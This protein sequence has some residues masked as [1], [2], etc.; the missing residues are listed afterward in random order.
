MAGRPTRSISRKGLELYNVDGELAHGPPHGPAAGR[1]LAVV[2]VEGDGRTAAEVVDR[3]PGG[4]SLAV[5]RR[6]AVGDRLRVRP[7]AEPDAPWEEV[8]VRH[9]RPGAGRLA[10][11]VPVRDRVAAGGGHRPGPELRSVAARPANARVRPFAAARL[12]DLYPDAVETVEM[13]TEA[14][15]QRFYAG[16]SAQAGTAIAVDW[17]GTAATADPSIAVG[18]PTAPNT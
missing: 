16:R 14:D 12:A 3:S 7:A 15:L 4:L 6:A 5:G 11:R 10:A 1:R 9:R 2:D 13:M 17:S 8:E 18:R